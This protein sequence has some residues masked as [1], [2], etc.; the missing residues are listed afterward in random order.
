MTRGA[1]GGGVDSEAPSRVVVKSM[2][3]SKKEGEGRRVKRE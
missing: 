2:G 1:V 3:R